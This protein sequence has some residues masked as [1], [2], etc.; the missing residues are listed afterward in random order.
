MESWQESWRDNPV[1]TVP[2][3]AEIEGTDFLEEYR[4]IFQDDF[5]DLGSW[6]LPENEVEQQLPSWTGGSY[7][8][9]LEG[10]EKT[11]P[12]H[13]SLVLKGFPEYTKTIVELKQVSSDPD[14]REPYHGA[15]RMVL[16][17]DSVPHS[18]E[19]SS[20]LPAA[21][22]PWFVLYPDSP[23]EQVSSAQ[24]PPGDQQEQQKE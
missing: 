9:E 1:Q 19:G 4:K 24:L 17:Q 14:Y 10:F 6:F 8:A 13:E 16:Q 20:C 7:L 23:G 5:G 11:V 15:S 2:V 12:I 21:P 22:Q 18:L 3:G